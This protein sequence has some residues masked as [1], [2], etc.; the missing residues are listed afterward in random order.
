M[1]IKINNNVF[2][3]CHSRDGWPG[4][5]IMRLPD[6]NFLDEKLWRQLDI[7]LL[8]KLKS[9]V[10]IFANFLQP[11]VCV[12]NSSSISL[13]LVAIKLVNSSFSVRNLITREIVY[14]H[15]LD[16]Y[17]FHQVLNH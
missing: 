15:T 9:G 7:E 3:D 12:R 6:S 1:R 2:F 4:E 10:W 11:L 5:T 17:R 8:V 16:N 13:I 14:N